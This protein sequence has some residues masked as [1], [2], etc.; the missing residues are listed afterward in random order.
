[1]LVSAT[2]APVDADV[3]GIGSLNVTHLHARAVVELVHNVPLRIFR[4]RERYSTPYVRTQAPRKMSTFFEC[5]GDQMSHML[6]DT[7]DALSPVVVFSIFSERRP[8]R[9]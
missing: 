9:C 7:N 2:Q 4:R 3:C 8:E 6:S 5:V 1:M